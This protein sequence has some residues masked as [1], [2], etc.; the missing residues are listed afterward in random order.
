MK[1]IFIGDISRYYPSLPSSPPRVR[2]KGHKPVKKI[3]SVSLDQELLMA[4]HDLAE[5]DERTV[6]ELIRIAIRRYLEIGSTQ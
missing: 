4:L 2:G 1:S 6:S 5:R 3:T